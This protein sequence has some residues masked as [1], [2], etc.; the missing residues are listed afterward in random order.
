MHRIRIATRRSRLAMV[1]AQSVA[2]ALRLS[3]P[4]L[5]VELV[6]ITTRGDRDRSPML[7]AAGGKD[8][9]VKALEEALAE[10]RADL[11]VH[12]MK[13]VGVAT[14]NADAFALMPFGARADVRD[15]LVTRTGGASLATLPPGTRIGTSSLRRQAFVAALR[16]DC[17]TLPLRGNVD[18]RL[19][20]L[21]VG[22]C[23][24]L[25]LACAGLDRLQ[26]SARID[27]RVDPGALLPAPCQ[28]ALAVQC[29]AERDDVCALLRTGIQQDTA[30]CI[31]AERALT[32]A[33][34]AD[35][36]MPLGALCTVEESS[37]HLRLRAAVADAQGERVLRAE[38]VGS[39]PEELAER[40]AAR[41]V[42]LG[43]ERLLA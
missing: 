17:E 43:A 18:T 20:R 39:V 36:A 21:D 8:S 28:G 19:K 29:L 38:A 11:A 10:N 27:Q 16:R 6:G 34:G 30:R 35:C 2:D 25:L 5:H 42:A 1:Q 37:G 41:L 40:V 14:A 9:F 3:A 24:A 23:D 4:D 31:A 22:D 26:R 33:L 7:A 32:R 15:A 12:S 13:D